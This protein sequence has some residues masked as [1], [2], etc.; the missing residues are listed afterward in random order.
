MKGFKGGASVAEAITVNDKGHFMFAN[1]DVVE[2]ANE[3][4]TPLFV[5]DVDRIR[6]NARA[7]VQGFKDLGVRAQVAYASKAF[8][9]VAMLQVAKQE[10]LSLDVVSEGE[11]YTA[12]KAGF[13][14]EKVHLHGNN[15][16][17]QELEMA[18]DHHIG[19]IV[20]DNFHEI[21]LLEEILAE[22]DQEIDCLLRVTPGIEAHTHDY[23]LTG[24]EDSKFGFDLNGQ[25][26]RAY[27]LIK[28][29]PK[30]HLKGLHCHIG[31]QIFE[32][33]GFLMAV[34]RLFEVLNDWHETD[35]FNAEVLNLG[36]G[37]GIRYTD[38]DEPLALES[39]VSALVEEVKAE[40]ERYKLD[41]PEIWIEPGRAI[42]G[43]AAITVYDIGAKKEIPNVRNYVSVNG[44]M[45]DNIRPA[46]YQAKYDCIVANKANAERQYEA[47]IAGKCCES[48]DM[49]LWDVLLPEVEAG[50]IL[51]V[52][53]TGAYGYSMASNYNRFPK[54]AVVFIENGVAKL[55]IK[56][57]TYQDLVKN[58]ISYE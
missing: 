7:F 6:R 42:V 51:A 44:G 46:L 52:F 39:Y 11:L 35:Q 4:G 57:E 56:R 55:V 22:K 53:S 14:M 15:K 3:F 16:N 25:S 20:V 45:T 23:I 13:P 50:D 32:T 31:S 27:D 33:D 38:E 1:R 9:S 2:L 19:C 54:A 5:Y 40:S 36:G 48:G 37:F 24:N 49:L 10:G 17:R 34:R 26:N 18:I 41:F 8:S 30:L 21:A 43:D 58:D 28:K 12:I 29:N 47:S